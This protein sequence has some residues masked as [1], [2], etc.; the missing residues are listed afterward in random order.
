MLIKIRTR[1]RDF[2]DDNRGSVSVEA[3]VIFPG[4]L[5]A[6]A[7]MYT[8]FD[9]YREQSINQKAAFTI[10]DM[11][12]RETDA[13]N[14]IYLSNTQALFDH[15]SH[16]AAPSK[17]RLS[18]LY[19]DESDNQFYADWSKTRGSVDSLTDA[20]LQTWNSKLPIVPNNERIILV[21]TWSTDVPLFNVGLAESE[22]ETFVFTSPRFA[23]Q[24]P[25]ED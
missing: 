25:W 13:I 2:I 10:A 16:S 18:V 20:T 23:P 9:S 5:W 14:E 1:L 6:F 17:L 3:M 15:L 12:S 19:W 7:A 22:Y 8:F 11:V 21:E 4:L 24:L